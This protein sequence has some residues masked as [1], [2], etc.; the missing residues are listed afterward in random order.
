MLNAVLRV[1]DAS[2]V[3]DSNLP[4]NVSAHNQTSS[5]R[6]H[7]NGFQGGHIKLNQR[8]SGQFSPQGSHGEGTK[9]DDGISDVS[10]KVRLGVTEYEAVRIMHDVVKKLIEKEERGWK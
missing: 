7:K 3:S 8:V 1:Q 6:M 5:N 4:N 2:P 9:A 10:N